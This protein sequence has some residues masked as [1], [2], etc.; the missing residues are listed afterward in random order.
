[1]VF[2]NNLLAG[3]GG[4]PTGYEIDQSIRFNDDDAAYLYRDVA[5]APTDGKKFTYSVWIKRGAITGGTNTALLSGGSGT[6]AGRCDFMFTAGAATGD[7][8]N[9]DSLKFD[10]YS[11]GFDQTRSI[12]K[13]RDPSS[14]YHIVFVFDAANATANDTMIMYLNGERLEL[15]STSGVPNVAAL[16]NANGQRTRIGADASNTPVE[17]DGYM[18]EI[19][20]ID[21]QA[22]APTN[23]GETND[24][25]VWVPIEYTG[26][27]GTNGFYITGADSSDLGEDFSG[28]NNDF[29][30]S[31]LTS[32][33]SVSDSPSDNFATWNPIIPLANGTFSDGN[34]VFTQSGGS[35][36]QH[37]KS[38][39]SFTFGEKKV[40]EM[41]TVSG[42]SITLGICDEDFIANANGFSGDSR[43][44]FDTN[45]NKVDKDGN[46]SS[47]GASFGTS[48]VIRIEV[49]LSSNPG[50]IEFFKDGVSQGDAFTDIT[51]TKTWF[52]WCRCKADAVKANFGQ[53]GFAGTPTSGFTALNA[54]N[55]PDPTITDPSAHFQTTLYTGNAS[56]QEVNQSGNSNFEPGFVWIKTRSNAASH[57]LFDQVRGVNKQLRSD[58]SG[59]EYTAYSDLLTAFDADGFTLGADATVNN[60]NV[61]TY[62]YAAW[63]WAADGTTGSSNSDGS[64]TSTVSANTTSGF[65][66]VKY[67]GTGA[68]ATVGHGL[69]AVP[70]MILIKDTTNVES[71]IVYHEAV[72]NDGNLY[73]NLTNAKAT[74]A[75]F[76]NTTPTSSVFYLGTTDGAN[77]ASGVHVAYCFA[78]I[79]GYSS[80]GSYTGNGST[81]GSFVYTGFKPAFV[82]LKRTNTAQEWQLYDNQRD[83]YNVANHK[84]EP[85]SSNAESIL[86]TDNNLDFLSNGF[87]LRQG[88]GGMNA[89][90]STYIY[91][92]FAESP[93][94][95]ATAR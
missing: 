42:S 28:N 38:T 57:A 91:M 10:I 61:N 71:W 1:M 65:S 93:F 2:S 11:G 73:L 26:S 47:Y 23:F 88:N 6:S 82:I 56:T 30:S 13:L 39:M 33:D 66:I 52:F 49:D 27:Y 79:P 63:Q 54:S 69:G 34:L 74:Q 78:E 12:A 64:I 45:G 59:A 15:D 85:N 86:T 87:K 75:I 43:G 21:G 25:G 44:Y 4:Q 72:G 80:I 32:A 19:N 67:T 8:S 31:G 16:I 76:Q 89:S 55:I 60:V 5:S 90:G 24:D 68:N 17:F 41:Q 37:A 95:T 18:A 22:L 14:W 83:P 92:A 77:K 40:C 94:K 20:M 53:L 50:T 7:G 9:N 48:N 84:L 46:S 62:T 58:S 29:T 35:I 36:S 3:A 51:S 81:D 70:K